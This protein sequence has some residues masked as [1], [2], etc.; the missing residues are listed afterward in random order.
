MTVIVV[1][2]LVSP[3]PEEGFLLNVQ[4]NLCL[5]TRE[6][7]FKMLQANDMIVVAVV[8]CGDLMS[9]VDQAGRQVIYLTSL[10]RWKGLCGNNEA[11][12]TGC[13]IR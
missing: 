11:K 7:L 2:T 12:T 4:P 3:P 10:F 5:T 6:G 9:K 8:E 1:V 13:H